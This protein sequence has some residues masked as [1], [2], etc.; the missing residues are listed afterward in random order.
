ME[1]NYL[2]SVLGIQEAD[3]EKDRVEIITEGDMIEKNGHTYITYKEYCEDNPSITSNN[4]IKIE[5][6]SKIMVIRRGETESRLILEE[7]KR[8][9]CFYRTIAG[10]LVIGIFTESLEVSLNKKGGKINMKYSIDFNNGLMS[11]N[12]IKIRIKEKS[13]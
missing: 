6:D 3:G 1:N 10:N 2:V 8:H 4:L 9:Q 12:E 11:N 7:G 13:K 5:S